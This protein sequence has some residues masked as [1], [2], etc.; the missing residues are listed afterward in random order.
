MEGAPPL[1]Q[2]KEEDAEEESEARVFVFSYLR[3]GHCMVRTPTVFDVSTVCSADQKELVNFITVNCTLQDRGKLNL[4]SM[5]KVDLLRHALAIASRTTKKLAVL[6]QLRLTPYAS[7]SD[8]D[9]MIML[10]ERRLLP[11]SNVKSKIKLSRDQLLWLV[12]SKS[13]TLQ[14]QP[15]LVNCAESEK[16]RRAVTERCL[17]AIQ[18]CFEGARFEEECKR[19]LDWAKRDGLAHRD[20]AM[21]L[22]R[23]QWL[24]DFGNIP[25]ASEVA[26]YL[27]RHVVP[28]LLVRPELI[29]S[30][31]GSWRVLQIDR[32]LW[33]PGVSNTTDESPTTTEQGF[34]ARIRKYDDSQLRQ[35][36]RMA[37]DALRKS[38]FSSS[39]TSLLKKEDS[40]DTEE[41]EL[42]N[43][44]PTATDDL[45][46][47]Y[48]ALISLRFW[49]SRVLEATFSREP[50]LVVPLQDGERIVSAFA[51]IKAKLSEL[52]RMI[53][54]PTG[55]GKSGVICLAPFCF[56]KR[57]VEMP[58]RRVLV[59]CPSIEI[60]EQM[61]ATFTTFY[62]QR[63]GL[64][65]P[66]DVPKVTEIC[67]SD[68]S[69]NQFK[70]YDVFVATFHRFVG[71]R[72]LADF[73]R[74]LFDLI[75]VDEAHHAEAL[76]YRLLREHFCKAQF[77]YFT[78]TPYRSDH[79]AI[80]AEL[81]YSCTMREALERE[82]PYIK[83]L[84]Y[85]PL[86]VKSLTLIG[87][88]SQRDDSIQQQQQQQKAFGSFQEVVENAAEIRKLFSRSTEAQSHVIGFIIWK[89]REMRKVSGVHHQAILQA[90]DL[91][92]ASFL[93]HLW[94]AHPENA[95]E[96]LLT[97]A[98]VHSQMPREESAAIITRLKSDKLDAIV[99]VGM[100]GEG[101]DHPHLSVCGIFRRF[102]SMPPFVQFVGRALRRIPNCPNETDN[103]G[104][105]IAH[106]GLGLHKHWSLY[107]KEVELP[108]DDDLTLDGCCSNC[109]WTDIQETYSYDDSH[110]DWF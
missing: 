4:S 81:V 44:A 11:P 40:E 13:S 1:S 74:S 83:H 53:V 54:L 82:N 89:V 98:A 91:S 105:V 16:C 15:V 29:L 85:L 43:M 77:V 31:H 39:K 72:L 6:A 33:Q 87:A 76:T 12:A 63:V 56:L 25:F 22:N 97:I 110:A 104:L 59:V 94:N 51:N 86:P 88:S 2:K 68:W 21:L 93:V 38:V 101:F 9:L 30:D 10:V 90:A 64:T 47:E 55:V 32:A 70:D 69:W 34:F 71:N 17:S 27:A 78:G 79:L 80:R 23:I 37:L 52:P 95:K 8:E 60:R 45:A 61:A 24:D 62:A 36:Q 66:K 57:K 75:L 48:D 65:D 107:K 3:E 58:F 103:V 73:P 19:F 26:K 42:T 96:E 99:H 28:F 50:Q 41:E 46:T 84:C 49:F 102:A 20:A 92:D 18:G 7:C 14:H 109:D 108:D 35:P 100:I 106:P 5:T 67:G